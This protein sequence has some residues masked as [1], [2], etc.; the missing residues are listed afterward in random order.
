MALQRIDSRSLQISQNEILC[1]ACARNERPRMP[2]F[3]DYHRRLG[4]HRFFIVDN[5]STDGTVDVL[6]GEPD[7]HVFSTDESYSASVCGVRW[8][9][10]L[11]ATHAVGRWALSVDIDELFAYPACEEVTLDRLA[12]YLE[13][14]DEQGVQAFLLDMYGVGAIRDTMYTPGRAF[15]DVC[16]YFDGDSYVWDP[17]HPGYG[18]VPLYGGPRQRV[19]WSR[20]PRD[21]P[22]PFLPKVPFVR[23]RADL[24]Y[25]VST[26]TL[27]GVRPSELTGV[28]LHF[29]FFSDFVHRAAEETRRGEHWESAGEYA[30]Y[31]EVLR[32]NPTLELVY[33]RSVRYEGTRQLVALG[34]LRAPAG[35]LVDAHGAP[36]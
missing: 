34:L 3:L 12:A 21:R 20:R 6:L 27:T 5:G 18:P 14:R 33:E 13:Q 22:A 29:K 1:V 24:A 4:I 25:T 32:D 10:D 15:L 8:M 9:N 28:I 19:F 30:I 35:F 2:H 16:P 23:W 36:A 26:H 17:A 31:D 11:L 7:V